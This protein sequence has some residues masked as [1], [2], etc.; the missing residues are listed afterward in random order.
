MLPRIAAVYFPENK[1]IVGEDIGL[2]L[3][4][5]ESITISYLIPIKRVE[6][7]KACDDTKPQ[8]IFMPVLAGFISYSY[9]AAT[10][11]ADTG[12]VYEIRVDEVAAFD[13]GAIA[14]STNLSLTRDRHSE[15]FAT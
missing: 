9:P 1:T 3:F 7:E 5:G 11:R 13:F 8:M 12:F 10:I 4:P 14:G 2:V 6:I 15:G